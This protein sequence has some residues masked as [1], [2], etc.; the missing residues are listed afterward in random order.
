M[1]VT[2]KPGYF[3]LLM[4]EDS[5]DHAELI[6]RSLQYADP[7]VEIHHV[8]DGAQALDY[9]F[10]Q[11]DFADTTD[12]PRP[13]L[14]LL[15]LNIPKVHGLDVLRESKANE[16]TRAI[17]VVVLSSSDAP[18]DVQAAYERHVNSYLLKPMSFADLRIL[19][20]SMTAYWSGHNVSATPN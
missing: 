18:K 2:S 4:V 14:M 5:P 12:H 13:D 10:N 6:R 7:P 16:H 9:L 11:G 20:S 8:S 19:M 15:D 17:P 3:R 1:K